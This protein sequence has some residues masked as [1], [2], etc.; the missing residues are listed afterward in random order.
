M[1]LKQPPAPMVPVVQGRPRPER[2]ISVVAIAM[3]LDLSG[4]SAWRDVQSLSTT[5]VAQTQLQGS[6]PGG[7]GGGGHKSA[8]TT[9]HV[10]RGG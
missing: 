2:L 1:R 9:R 3:V 7:R 5:L 6:P 10:T 4:L 8:L